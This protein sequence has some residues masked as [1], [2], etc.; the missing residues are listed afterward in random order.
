VRREALSDAGLRRRGL[1]GRP[2][3]G[4]ASVWP[5]ASLSLEF[6]QRFGSAEEARSPFGPNVLT[7]KEALEVLGLEAVD[8]LSVRRAYLGLLRH[9]SP[10][11]DPVGFQRLRAAYELLGAGRSIP[12][13]QRP[14]RVASKLPRQARPEHEPPKEQPPTREALESH[15]LVA[16]RDVSA[17]L[18]L[19]QQLAEAGERDGAIRLLRRGLDLGLNECLAVLARYAPRTLSDEEFETYLTTL[20]PPRQL[21]LGS[22]LMKEGFAERAASALGAGLVGG[23]MGEQGRLYVQAV[24][25]QCLLQ[26]LSTGDGADARALWAAAGTQ[27]SVLEV[28]P[29]DPQHVRIPFTLARELVALPPEFPKRLQ[30]R[31][32]VSVLNGKFPPTLV[33]RL[34][35]RRWDGATLKQ[36]APL[37]WSM[38][39]LKKRIVVQRPL[40]LAA[41]L[42]LLVVLGVG[43]TV[44]FFSQD[45]AESS[46]ASAERNSR[47]LCEFAGESSDVCQNSLAEVDLLALKQCQRAAS[48]YSQVQANVT[49]LGA[50]AAGAR[51]P[52]PSEYLRWMG[53]DYERLC[54]ENSDNRWAPV[55]Q[56]VHASELR[57]RRDTFCSFANGLGQ[58]ESC[59]EATRLAAAV[60]AQDCDA[61]AAAAGRLRA[62][63]AGPW[64]PAEASRMASEL[65]R[66]TTY[67]RRLCGA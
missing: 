33:G 5:E 15:L 37:L 16:P 44:L 49:S 26:L 20:L 36:E 59:Q 42:A 31:L 8:S 19:F 11:S 54:G 40:V 29:S 65:S 64:A 55:A 38:V 66:F 27:A 30:A 28:L 13:A 7:R 57:K 34:L 61:A 17:R 58:N 1:R 14:V 25:A 24:L 48:V 41:F 45:R 6:R 12:G 39:K 10:E 32:A 9:H 47:A 56:T 18:S 22:L 23:G 63:L 67:A 35:V 51:K 3:A 43:Q 52:P 50:A 60:E 62:S 4:G 21:E 46:V 2:L 53:L